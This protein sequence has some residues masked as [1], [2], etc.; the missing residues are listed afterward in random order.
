MKRLLLGIALTVCLPLFAQDRAQ[1][2]EFT[3]YRMR[4]S[5]QITAFAG[6]LVVTATS[7]QRVGDVDSSACILQLRGNVEIRAN[8]VTVQA[9][10]ADYH[11]QTGEIEPRGNVH[12]KIV[13]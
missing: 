2:Y 4:G 8:N 1:R 6:Q 13:Q 11:C 5:Y 3:V 9:D 10:E 12:L 7:M